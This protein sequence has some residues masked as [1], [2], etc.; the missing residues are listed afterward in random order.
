M[1]QLHR[2]IQYCGLFDDKVNDYPWGD[3]GIS[4]A[5]INEELVM[6]ALLRPAMALNDGYLMHYDAGRTALINRRQSPLRDLIEAGFIVI[7]SRNDGKLHEMPKKVAERVPSYK[8]LLRSATWPE[9]ERE[10]KKLSEDEP[11]KRQIER[12]PRVDIGAGLYNLLM[13][14]RGRTPQEL[15]IAGSV[16]STHLEKVFTAFKSQFEASPQ[17]GPRGI[18]E[19]IL[20]ESFGRDSKVTLELMKL[21]NEAYHHNF[22]AC[23]LGN[24]QSRKVGVVTRYSGIF[25][26]L[27]DVRAKGFS[28]VVHDYELWL[29]RIPRYPLLFNGELLREVVTP[30]TRLNEAKLKWCQ[31]FEDAIE[32]PTEHNAE[33]TTWAA[34]TYGR[35]L[36]EWF[37]PGK[38]FDKE[39]AKKA[40]HTKNRIQAGFGAAATFASY[41]LLTLIQ[42]VTG[43][44]IDEL[45]KI[46]ISVLLGTGFQLRALVMGE[47]WNERR[48]RSTARRGLS[49]PVQDALK[50]GKA[51]S[52]LAM[53]PN[54][55]SQHVSSLQVWNDEG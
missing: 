54:Q 23:L 48:A 16:D 38:K 2:E 28:D 7:L 15:G 24:D 29:P 41:G 50:G 4:L 40:E 52:A 17:K 5:Y 18:W 6:Q 55:T 21:A 34:E 25:A 12:W 19:E 47:W 26:E 33:I 13:N 8:R 43:T 27:R 20:E 44:P 37:D 11:F 32:Q 36:S 42:K 1:D 45:Q 10:L 53:N 3:R 30:G 46:T 14:L 9:L 35:L 51:M 49:F 39:D 31:Y 22:A